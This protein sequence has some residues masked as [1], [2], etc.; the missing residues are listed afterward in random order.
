[1][2]VGWAISTSSEDVIEENARELGYDIET[3]DVPEN[4]V[5]RTCTSRNRTWND[6]CKSIDELEWKWA[7]IL[8]A[9]GF[10]WY[11]EE[12]HDSSNDLVGSARIPKRKLFEWLS[13]CDGVRRDARK[14]CFLGSGDQLPSEIE[15][16][17]N[18]LHSAVDFDF[19]IFDIPQK[20]FDEYDVFEK[21]GFDVADRVWDRLTKI[22]APKDDYYIFICDNPNF[23]R[24]RSDIIYA[25]REA[26]TDLV[27]GVET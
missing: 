22:K 4:E 19:E 14:L 15:C 26:I 16:F 25:A 1:V 27:L 3:Q 11:R 12:G 5:Y 20:I 2:S 6:I 24:Y 23:N 8:K 9:L 7:D 21:W 10:T 13:W 17:A 18:G